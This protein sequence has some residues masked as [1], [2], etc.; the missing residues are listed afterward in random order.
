M[1][2]ENKT[3]DLSGGTLY[4]TPLEGGEPVPLGHGTMTV[5]P[6]EEEPDILGRDPIRI[7]RGM[8]FE[9]ELEPDAEAWQKFREMV[10]EPVADAYR[11]YILDLALKYI[12]WCKENHPDW[13][14]I[15]RRTKKKRTRKKYLGRL[16][17]AWMEEH[18]YV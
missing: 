11:R 3:L 17:R 15:L 9:V 16:R 7:N 2:P 1:P 10:I 12:A 4:I 14:H 13:V 18:G 5:I 6:V 8:S